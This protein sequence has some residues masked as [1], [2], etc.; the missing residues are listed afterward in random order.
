[1]HIVMVSS[2]CSIAYKNVT[3]GA[4]NMEYNMFLQRKQF[5]CDTRHQLSEWPEN[6]ILQAGLTLIP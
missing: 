3:S 2:V 1:M 5:I 4:H 6:M